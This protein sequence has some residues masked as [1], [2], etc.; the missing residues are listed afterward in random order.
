MRLTTEHAASSYGQPVLV[1]DDGTAYGPGDAPN[2]FGQTPAQEVN[3]AM[4]AWAGR[5]QIAL[6][7]GPWESA[8]AQLKPPHD[9]T[10][11][12]KFCRLG[13]ISS[14]WAEFAKRL[15]Q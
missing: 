1:S 13:G 12:D 8:A 4:G 9:P 3:E 5:V 6:S 10:L 14:R 7:F 11:A 15:A 2:L